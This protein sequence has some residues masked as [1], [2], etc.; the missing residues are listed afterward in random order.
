MPQAPFVAIPQ[1]LPLVVTPENRG[2]VTTQDAKLVNAYTEKTAD[3]EY[4]LYKRPGTAT[5]SQPSGGAATGRG[6]WNWLGNIYSIFGATA[7]KDGVAL[8]GTLNT[9]NGLYRFDSCK[10]ATPKMQFGDGVKAYNYDSSGGIVLINDAD[11]PAAFVKGWAYLDGTTYV[12]TTAAAIQGDELN[13]PVSWNILN[14]IYAYIEPDAGVALAKQL[15]YVIFFKQWSTEVF[16][17]AAN[18]SGSPLSP[19]PSA[20][21]NQGCAAEGSVCE[22]DGMLFWVAINKSNSVSVLKMDQLKATIISTDSIQR[23]LSAA[24][25]TTTWSFGI[26]NGSHRFYVLTLKVEN[27]TLVYDIDTQMWSQ[28]TD[29]DGNYWPFVAATY[30]STAGQLLQHESNGYIYTLDDANYTDAGS[31]ITVDIVTPNFDGGTNRRKQLNM[32]KVIADQTVGSTLW[33]RYNDHDYSA[34][35]W[36]N[37]R[38]VDLSHKQPMLPSCGTFTR[39]AYHL[40]HQSHTWFRVKAL[41]LQI[42]LGTL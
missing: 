41:E 38:K 35:R 17:D 42:D 32:L 40:R 39:R 22:I 36:S 5:S 19:L 1:R 11:F 28:W 24:D 29:V 16:Y 25:F 21:I 3:G 31:I 12:A 34:T 20:K 8:S 9:T 23:L 13:D 30:S 37:F 4:W 18:T 26:K 6:M 2:I 27:I 14:V 33:I 10:G 15:T 7:Y